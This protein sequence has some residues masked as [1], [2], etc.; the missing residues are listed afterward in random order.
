MY[1]F[2]PFSVEILQH[3]IAR[4]LESY[5]RNMRPIQLFCYYPSD[6]YI[7]YLMN[8]EELQFSDEIDCKDLFPG[9]N[10]RE[11]IVVFELGEIA[12]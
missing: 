5:Y 1:F 6:D 8:V 4:I 9:E 7:A 3:V 11:R 10:P 2:N 12:G